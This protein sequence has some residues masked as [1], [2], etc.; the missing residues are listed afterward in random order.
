MRPG[1]PTADIYTEAE[2]IAGR[3]GLADHFMG[4]GNEKAGFCGHGI[5][6]E[7]D[8]TPIF[9]K[10][11]KGNIEPGIAFA[12]EPKFT[13]PGEG[14]VGVED[15]YVMTEKGVEKLTKSSY[16]VEIRG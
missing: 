13:F 5:G 3:N 9:S 14:I 10:N 2:R 15:S 1:I 11:G 7:L 8:E 6:I 4:Y 16:V 12:L